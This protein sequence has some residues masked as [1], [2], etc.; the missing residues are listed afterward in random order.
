MRYHLFLSEEALNQLRALPKE[1]RRNI[2]QRIDRL[3]TDL[4][5]DVKKLSAREDKYRLR[6]GAF[7]CKAT[8][9]SSMPLKTAKKPT[10][11]RRARPESP[12][13]LT[14]LHR[15]VTQLRARVEGL[16]DLRELNESIARNVGKPGIPWE[17]AKT[18][19]GI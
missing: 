19:L 13:S 16:E 4:T 17:Q 2:G 11:K 7:S 12:T 5:G 8:R 18:E 9:F 15:E 1:T 14:A 3:Q 10:T 6:V